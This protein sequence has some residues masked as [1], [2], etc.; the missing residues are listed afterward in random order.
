MSLY[1]SSTHVIAV[2]WAAI[3]GMVTGGTGS[4][5]LLEAMTDDL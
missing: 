5:E 4:E 3:V 1:R 2:H